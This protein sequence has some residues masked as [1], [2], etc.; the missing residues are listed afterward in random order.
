[1]EINPAPYRSNNNMLVPWYLMAG[2]TYEHLDVSIIPNSEYDW[3][4]RKLYLRWNR[5]EHRHKYLVARSHLPSQTA[6]G[7][8]FDDFPSII[9]SAAEGL[10]VETG[11]LENFYRLR[12]I[13]KYEHIRNMKEN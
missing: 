12:S 3:I 11:E 8:D 9:I 2:Y 13:Y 4:C 10:V 5:V 6:S 7:L 1:M